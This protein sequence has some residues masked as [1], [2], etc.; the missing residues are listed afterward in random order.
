MGFVEGHLT[1]SILEFRTGT[2]LTQLLL[3]NRIKTRWRV[4]CFPSSKGKCTGKCVHLQ[5][6]GYS[7]A[8]LWLLRMSLPLVPCCVMYRVFRLES[9][10][11]QRWHAC[12]YVLLNIL[13]GITL[14]LA[15]SLEPS[16]LLFAY[17]AIVKGHHSWWCLPFT[18]QNCDLYTMTKVLCKCV[19]LCYH[20]CAATCVILIPV[21][22][23]WL[24]WFLPWPWWPCASSLQWQNVTSI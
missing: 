14:S 13:L 5:A 11:L 18:G 22:V 24:F 1:A 3:K 15:I 23:H 12:C 6:V 10:R 7:A 2:R 4:V 16:Y 8:E 17:A 21:C 19:S 9:S 20:Y